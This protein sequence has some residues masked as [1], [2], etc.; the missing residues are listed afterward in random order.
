MIVTSTYTDIGARLLKSPS[1]IPLL[2]QNLVRQVRDGEKQIKLFKRT[3]DIII[4][5]TTALFNSVRITVFTQQSVKTSSLQSRATQFQFHNGRHKDDLRD[6]LFD[7]SPSTSN[8]CPKSKYAN[9]LTPGRRN[10]PYRE[11]KSVDGCTEPSTG[12]T[13]I[14]ILLVNSEEYRVRRE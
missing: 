14:S 8:N 6:P 4:K 1:H 3:Y 5:I 9:V 7:G 12:E 10:D 13:E 2:Y 11:Q